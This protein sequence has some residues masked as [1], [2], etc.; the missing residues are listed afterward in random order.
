MDDLFRR[1]RTGSLQHVLLAFTT[2]FSENKPMGGALFE[3]GGAGR[4]GQY[5]SKK[6]LRWYT[7]CSVA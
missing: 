5:E 7:I 1:V 4:T 2:R 3:V 6:K